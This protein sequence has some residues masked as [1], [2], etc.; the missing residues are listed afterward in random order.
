M[1]DEFI[2]NKIIQRPKRVTFHRSCNII[3]RQMWLALEKS[4]R[5]PISIL[6]APILGGFSVLF[7]GGVG[8]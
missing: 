2:D 1:L 7:T 6:T 3:H 4:Y 5:K 8:A